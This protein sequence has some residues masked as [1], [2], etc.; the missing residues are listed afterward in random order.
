M[1]RAFSVDEAPDRVQTDTL[2]RRHGDLEVADV[3]QGVIRGVIADAV[4][5]DAL[6]R[7]FDHVIGKEFESEQALAA[8]MDD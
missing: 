5:G 7:Q 4:G 3:V 2:R 6:G 1:D 8:V